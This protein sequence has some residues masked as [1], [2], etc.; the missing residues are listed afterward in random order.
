MPTGGD[1]VSLIERTRR[2]QAP[3]DW[4]GR[5][6]VALQEHGILGIARIAWYRFLDY[7]A[8]RRAR[9]SN[10]TFD[11]DFNVETNIEVA[12]GRL[13][14][15]GP[16]RAFG[17]AYQATPP[18]RII[19]F[20]RTLPINY[21]D[22]SFVDLGSGKGRVTLVASRFPFRAVLGVEFGREL[23]DIAT[24]NIDSYTGPV[25]TKAQSI[26]ADATQFAFPDGNLVVFLNNPFHGD[27]LERV[28]QNLGRAASDQRKVYLIY[29]NSWERD[30]FFSQEW[31]R[32][33]RNSDNYCIFQTIPETSE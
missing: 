14:N 30:L 27:V 18:S 12:L 11:R 29:W 24:R 23:H 6:K 10:Q 4:R 13:T 26:C 20:I 2:V 16:S 5:L 25:K 28:L 1:G 31:L 21:V 9:A 32:L 7:P 22:Y 33:Y 17:R 8:R 19:E 3:P 15:P